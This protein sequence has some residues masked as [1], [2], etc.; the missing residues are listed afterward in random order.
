MF[1]LSP[2]W[3]RAANGVVHVHS[4]PNR[5]KC[6]QRPQ[7]RA[8]IN[9]HRGW[10]DFRLQRVSPCTRVAALAAALVADRVVNLVATPIAALHSRRLALLHLSLFLRIMRDILRAILNKPTVPCQACAG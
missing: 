3:E 1:S 4:A 2:Q 6:H 7:Q 5:G 10:H 9:D 8:R